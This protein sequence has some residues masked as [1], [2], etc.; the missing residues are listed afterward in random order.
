[1]TRRQ[2]GIFA[3]IPIHQVPSMTYLNLI[4]QNMYWLDNFFKVLICGIRNIFVDV[5]TF[6]FF[7]RHKKCYVCAHTMRRQSMAGGMHSLGL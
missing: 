1:M 2:I 5:V 7:M 3:K 4:D 6:T